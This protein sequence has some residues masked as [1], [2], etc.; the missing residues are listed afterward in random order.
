MA[1]APGTDE[2]HS[3]STEVSLWQAH[4]KGGPRKRWRDV[5]KSDLRERG[6]DESEWMELATESRQVWRAMYRLE[7]REEP[8]NPTHGEQATNQVLHMSGLQ[9]S[10]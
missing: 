1:R 6:I 9:K 10:V 5:V 4:P 3:D 7:T 8:H 2:C